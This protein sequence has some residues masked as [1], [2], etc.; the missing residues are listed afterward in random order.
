[1]SC[2]EAHSCSLAIQ[3]RSRGEPLDKKERLPRDA[4]S[5]STDVAF[6]LDAMLVRNSR[7]TVQLKWP[8]RCKLA[9]LLYK[10]SKRKAARVQRNWLLAPAQAAVYTQNQGVRIF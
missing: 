1:M 9:T 2:P 5:I 8:L 6:R 3:R 10:D 7:L 4:E